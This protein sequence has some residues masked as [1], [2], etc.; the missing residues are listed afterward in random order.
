MARLKFHGR[1]RN[2][3]TI[4]HHNLS[5]MAPTKL[6]FVCRKQR[7]WAESLIFS[8]PSLHA[9]V[10]IQEKIKTKCFIIIIFF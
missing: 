5:L 6:Y 10:Q 1:P 7:P 3:T 8:Q 2:L 4:D 9:A